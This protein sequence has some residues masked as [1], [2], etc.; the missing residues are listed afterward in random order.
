MLCLTKVYYSGWNGDVN[1]SLSPLKLFEI[2]HGDIHFSTRIPRWHVTS[3]WTKKADD[4]IVT[5]TG[6]RRTS[7]ISKSMKTWF[8]TNKLPTDTYWDFGWKT[9]SVFVRNASPD[10]STSWAMADAD[11]AA[12]QEGGCWTSLWEPGVSQ[13]T[14]WRVGKILPF[15]PQGTRTQV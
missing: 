15:V 14:S 11:D 5:D 13:K 12:A 6:I 9:N 8:E 3:F 10:L 1:L 4:R 2:S 7:W